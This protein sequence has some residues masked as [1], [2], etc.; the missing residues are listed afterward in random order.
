MFVVDQCILKLCVCYIGLWL[1]E[2]GV[3][4]A[5][6]DGIVMR[7]PKCV[8]HHQTEAANF[9]PPELIEVKCPYSAR[10]LSVYNAACTVKDFFLG[11]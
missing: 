5:S 1:H 10:D 6:P 3:L 7:P 2:S 11:K 4:G 8:V 9:T